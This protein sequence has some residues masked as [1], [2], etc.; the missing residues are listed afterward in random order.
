[1]VKSKKRTVKHQK[2]GRSESVSMEWDKLMWSGFSK[3]IVAEIK[4]IFSLSNIILAK[5]KV[6]RIPK[7]AISATIM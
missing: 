7:E 4:A 6:E 5:K 3:K 1:M 2:V